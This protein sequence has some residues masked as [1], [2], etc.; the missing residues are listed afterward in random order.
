MSG[1]VHRA[2]RRA[3]RRRCARI[4]SRGN[5][6][7][8]RELVGDDRQHAHRRRWRGC[9]RC[10][11]RGSRPGRRVRRRSGGSR[12][13][14]GVGDVTTISGIICGAVF[15]A[16]RNRRL[17]SPNGIIAAPDSKSARAC[18]STFLLNPCPVVAPNGP[19][20]NARVTTADER[21]WRPHGRMPVRIRR[22]AVSE[23]GGGV[24]GREPPVVR[25]PEDSGLPAW[26]QASPAR[27][28]L[29]HRR[30][31]PRAAGCRHRT[32]RRLAACDSD[33]RQPAGRGRVR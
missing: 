27:E 21:G 33:G 6:R 22:Q 20:S 30:R 15:C 29:Q 9:G 7:D 31:L 28:V 11:R 16:G 13:R 1:L 14:I 18:I 19:R 8:G 25:R 10:G 12:T 26:Q 4:S 32:L 2:G 3:S 24:F 23:I 5:H 17:R